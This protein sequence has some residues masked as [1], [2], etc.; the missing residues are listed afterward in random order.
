[1]I[2]PGMSVIRGMKSHSPDVSGEQLVYQTLGD[3]NGFMGQYA[4]ATSGVGYSTGGFSPGGP[5]TVDSPSPY[6]KYSY[7]KVGTYSQGDVHM[8]Q[9]ELELI[10]VFIF[11]KYVYRSTECVEYS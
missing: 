2:F 7:V 9:G 6:D 11:K 1:M 4:A 5:P 10:S 3:S 8:V